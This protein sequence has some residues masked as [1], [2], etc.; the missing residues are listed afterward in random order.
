MYFTLWARSSFGTLPSTARLLLSHFLIRNPPLFSR[1]VKSLMRLIA[2]ASYSKYY[3]QVIDIEVLADY[4]NDVITEMFFVVI[5]CSTQGIVSSARTPHST[6]KV[7]C[8]SENFRFSSHV[9]LIPLKQ[10][11]H[12][13]ML[14]FDLRLMKHRID[15]T[16]DRAM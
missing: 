10:P 12:I 16:G 1:S 8:H 9:N 2:W 7:S 13:S 11:Q 5:A 3:K 4:L 15:F 6:E 14:F